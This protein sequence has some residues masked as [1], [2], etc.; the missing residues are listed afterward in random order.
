MLNVNVWVADKSF[1]GTVDSVKMLTSGAN[2]I[3]VNSPS[4]LAEAYDLFASNSLTRT[5]IIIG[6]R[7]NPTNAPENSISSYLIA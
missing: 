5:P 1:S 3:V 6:H 7:G 2:G 4:K